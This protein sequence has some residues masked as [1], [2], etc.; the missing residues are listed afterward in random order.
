MKNSERLTGFLEAKFSD[1]D[2][3]YHR[4]ILSRI[5][6]TDK[7][8]VVITP[9][10]VSINSQEV[11]DLV[12]KSFECGMKFQAQMSKNNTVYTMTLQDIIEKGT[13][14]T[15]YALGESE[16]DLSDFFQ[17]SFRFTGFTV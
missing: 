16:K 5:E 4:D 13:V 10:C 11:N 1:H 9:S 7:V 15:I 14:V 12:T 17:E 6:K 3:E 2:H 8:F